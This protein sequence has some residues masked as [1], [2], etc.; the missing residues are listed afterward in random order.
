M[1]LRSSA[2][3]DGGT[4]SGAE[5]IPLQDV[6]DIVLPS[7]ALP[8]PTPSCPTYTSRDSLSVGRSS[9]SHTDATR[10]PPTPAAVERTTG[11]SW[12][13][14]LPAI[15]LV[16]VTSLMRLLHTAVLSRCS[17]SQSMLPLRTVFFASEP[18]FA[19][20]LDLHVI[21]PLAD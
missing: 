19:L 21:V 2:S 8:T 16:S 14:R 1:P 9:S 7:F 10:Q 13:H 11:L 3:E 20:P 15:S 18:T 5:L 4:D 6:P 12:V 17:D